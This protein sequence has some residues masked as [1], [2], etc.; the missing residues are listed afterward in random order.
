MDQTMEGP[1][2]TINPNLWVRTG[3]VRKYTH[4]GLANQKPAP[5][6][7]REGGRKTVGRLN[8]RV[9][10]Q[11]VAYAD[12]PRGPA[13][14]AGTPGLPAPHPPLSR[15]EYNSS[16]ALTSRQACAERPINLIKMWKIT[17]FFCLEKCL[18]LWIYPL[19]IISKNCA[20]HFCRDTTNENKHLTVFI[21]K[22]HWFQTKLLRVPLKIV[23]SH[24]CITGHLKLRLQYS[25]FQ[26]QVY[27]SSKTNPDNRD[28]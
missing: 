23:H 14:N 18:F 19:F 9:N 8:R 25:L 12:L 21:N 28:I 22:Q 2:P 3:R 11:R 15:V 10:W 5:P 7:S 4:Y 27:K 16:P 13:R 17:S 1:R 20:G 24:L 26:S 6:E